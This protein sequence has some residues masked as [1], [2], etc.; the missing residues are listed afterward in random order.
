MKKRKQKQ[1]KPDN[2]KPERQIA[3]SQTHKAFSVLWKGFGVLALIFGVVQGVASFV[4]R[5]SV[6]NAS[7]L[8]P[9]DPFSTPFI[10]SNDGMLDIYSIEYSCA[11]NFIETE[12]HNIVSDVEAT[13]W[14]PGRQ[15]LSPAEKDSFP[16]GLKGAVEALGVFPMV[17]IKTADITLNISFRPRFIVWKQTKSFR[18]ITART[19]DNQLQWLPKSLK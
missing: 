16:C 2:N 5:L 4:P 3:E 13:H 17:S 6:Y 15:I 12:S 8:N 14:T 7:A 1:H 11:G 9:S 10:L 19:S 18:F